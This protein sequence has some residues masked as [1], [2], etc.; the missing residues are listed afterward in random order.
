MTSHV[1][2]ND[3][4]N[5]FVTGMNGLG[6]ENGGGPQL[7]ETCNFG[8][9][10]SFG[11]I[12][13]TA[14]TIF[15]RYFIQDADLLTWNWWLILMGRNEYE[16]EYQLGKVPENTIKRVL[17]C[18][19]CDENENCFSNL[20]P[21]PY[22]WNIIRV[23]NFIPGGVWPPAFFPKAGFA[24]CTIDEAGFFSGQLTQ[25]TI[26]GTLSFD[27][28]DSGTENETYTMAGY[29]YQRAF[30]TTIE[31]KLAVI[32]PMHRTYC[33]SDPDAQE[34]PSRFNPAPTIWPNGGANTVETCVID[35]VE[36]APINP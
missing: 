26:T 29:A 21:I 32:H 30:P 35:G 27:G 20:I 33:S 28:V 8:S 23:G 15:P 2:I 14:R 16:V 22:E 10:S 7:E 13:I 6:L 25:T 3:N 19:F 5:G 1:Y 4:V 24:I 11:P 34:L 18:F 17:N 9:C 12:G 31:Q 36:T